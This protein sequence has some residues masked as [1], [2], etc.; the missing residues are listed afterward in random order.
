M[1]YDRHK[2]RAPNY[3]GPAQTEVL[4]RIHLRLSAVPVSCFIGSSHIERFGTPPPNDDEFRF[5]E[6]DHNGSD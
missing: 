2:L 4:I 5:I 3:P 1:S 6:P